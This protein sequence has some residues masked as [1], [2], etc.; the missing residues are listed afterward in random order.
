MAESEAGIDAS[1]RKLVGNERRK[2]AAGA[3]DGLSTAFLAVGVLG[4]VL[5]LKPES[6]TMSGLAVF[7]G[8][9]LGAAL[10]HWAGHRILGGLKA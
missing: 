1:R 5:S 6:T 9:I 2:L 10:L 8:W 7:G 3:L 4:Q